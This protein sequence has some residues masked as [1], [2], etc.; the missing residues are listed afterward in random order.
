MCHSD[1]RNAREEQRTYT[2]PWVDIERRLRIP[3]PQ[4]DED[5]E[6]WRVCIEPFDSMFTE[7]RLY[8]WGYKAVIE[9]WVLEEVRRLLVDLESDPRALQGAKGTIVR[10]G[11]KPAE[12]PWSIGIDKFNVTL[13]DSVLLRTIPTCLVIE[14]IRFMDA[15]QDARKATS[16]D[17]L[18]SGRGDIDES[19]GP[20]SRS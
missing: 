12:E 18:T 4:V 11:E 15:T 19:W 16:R 6:P 17:V 20:C 13:G 3:E 2:T 10:T 14:A 1:D 9:L 8:W 5:L 7:C